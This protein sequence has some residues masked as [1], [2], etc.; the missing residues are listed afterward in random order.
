MDESELNENGEKC[1]CDEK[2]IICFSKSLSIITNVAIGS[3]IIYNLYY[4]NLHLI[5]LR[6]VIENLF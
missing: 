2:N 5:E 3:I 1:K 6:D 4:I